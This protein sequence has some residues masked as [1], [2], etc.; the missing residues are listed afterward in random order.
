MFKIKGAYLGMDCKDV[1]LPILFKYCVCLRGGGWFGPIN[2]ENKPMPLLRMWYNKLWFMVI[3]E[4]ELQGKPH[5]SLTA[6][7]G[8][9]M[10]YGLDCLL[11]WMLVL[12]LFK[13]YV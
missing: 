4:L 13:I 10:I 5:W 2:G 9:F 12:V 3:L 11:T 6:S 8:E 7:L 1:S